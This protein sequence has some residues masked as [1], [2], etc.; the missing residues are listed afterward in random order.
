MNGRLVFFALGLMLFMGFFVS[1]AT[2]SFLGTSD[3][4]SRYVQYQQPDFRHYYSSSQ[5]SD[6]WPIL[7]QGENVS[8][9]NRQDLLISVAPAG[10]QPSVLRSDLLAEQNVPIFCQLDAFRVNPLID[11]KQIRNIRFTGTYPK[12]VVGVG[13]HP[14]LAALQSRNELLGSPFLNNIGYVVVVLR[15][16][17]NESQQPDFINF[18]LQAQVDYYAGNALGV[19]S[20]SFYLTPVNDDAWKTARLRQSFFNGRYFVRLDEVDGERARISL[21]Y[22]DQKVGSSTLALGTR[23]DNLLYLPGSYCQLGLR[24]Y[25]D[26]Y[27]SA[28]PLA[29]LQVGDDRVAVGEGGRFANDRCSVRSLQSDGGDAGTVAMTCG[30]RSFTLSLAPKSFVVNDQVQ[31]RGRESQGVFTIVSFNASAQNYTLR[32][33]TG[34]VETV[35]YLLVYSTG[36]AHLTEAEHSPELESYFNATLEHYRTLARDY[37]LDKRANSQALSSVDSFGQMGLERAITLAESLGKQRTAVELITLYLQTYPNAQNSSLFSDRL[38][39]LYSYDSSSAV[40]VVDLNGQSTTIRL[41]GLAMP[42]RRSHATFSWGQGSRFDV[43]LESNYSLGSA[44]TLVVNSLTDERVQVTAVC[45]NTVAGVGARGESYTLALRSA[46]GGVNDQ[47]TATVCGN[48]L[49]L[50]SIALER[51]A[52]IR[53]VPEARGPTIATNFSVGVGIEKRAIQLS[54]DKAQERIVELNKTIQRWESLSTNLGNVVK[55]L[56]AACFATAGVLTVKNFVTGLEGTALARQKVMRGPSGWTEWCRDHVNAHDAGPSYSS[57]GACYKENSA[58]IDHDVS[59]MTDLINADNQRI[60]A[61]ERGYTK[62]DGLFGSY[63]EGE[64]A[65]NTFIAQE[66]SQYNGQTIRLSDGSVVSVGNLTRQSNGAYALTYQE[67]KDLKLYLDLRAHAGDSPVAQSLANET[68]QRIAVSTTDRITADAQRSSLSSRLGSNLGKFVPSYS[69]RFAQRGEWSNTYLSDQDIRAL[70]LEGKASANT[71]AQVIAGDNGKTYLVLLKSAGGVDE[72]GIDKSY[73]LGDNGKVSGDPI[74]GSVP[75][76]TFSTFRKVSRTSCINKFSANSAEVQFY[77][78]EPYKGMPAIVPFDLEQGWYV[79]TRQTVAGLGGIKAFQSSGRPASFWVCNVGPDGRPDFFVSGFDDDI[80][81]QFN[82]DTGAPLNKFSCLSESE[83]REVV[84]RAIR[85]LED[86]A[87]QRL[88]GATSFVRIEG[89]SMKVGAP[90]VAIPGTQCQDFMSPDDCKLLFNVCD[91][92]IC[93]ASRCNFGGKYPVTDVIQSGIVGSVLLCLPNVNEGV[94]M[95]VCLTGI[96][97]GIDGYV[98]VLK[99]HQQCLQE[100]INSGKYIGICDQI[101]AIYMCEFFWRQAAP[102]ANVLLPKLVESLYGQSS[103]ARGGGEYAT[104]QAAWDNAQSSVNYFTQSYAVNSFK[105]FNI[106]SV[107]DAGGEFCKAFISAK[108]PTQFESLIE[109]DSPP[110]FHAWFSQ[111]PYTD[112]TVPATSQYKVFYHIF[113]GNDQGV[114]YQV[115]LKDPPQTSYYQSTSTIQVDG[116]YVPRGEYRTETRDFT[117]PSGYQQ[118][119]VRV[120]D[121]EECGFKE[122]TTSFALNAIRDSFVKDELKRNDITS[123]TD[124]VSGRTNPSALLNPNLQEAAQEALDPAIYNRGVTRICAT[125][126]PGRATD[127]RRFV[128]VGTCND[129]RV[130]CWLDTQSVDRA[131][132]INNVGVRNATLSELERINQEQLKKDDQFLVGEGEDLQINAL[133]EAILG[134]PTLVASEARPLISRAEDLSTHV[135]LNSQKAHLLFLQGAAYEAVT[136]GLWVGIVKQAVSAQNLSQTT[137]TPQQPSA[138]QPP[139]S[140]SSQSLTFEHPI[141]IEYPDASLFVI[142][143]VSYRYNPSKATWEYTSRVDWSAVADFSGFAYRPSF[144]A[145]SQKLVGKNENEGLSYLAQ[146]TVPANKVIRD[147]PSTDVVSPAGG[148]PVA[149]LGRLDASTAAILM[150]VRNGDQVTQRNSGL[151]IIGSEVKFG[152]VKV[153]D[154]KDDVIIIDEKNRKL[155]IPA[156]LLKMAVPADLVAL[157]EARLSWATFYKITS[158]SISNIAFVRDGTASSFDDATR[159]SM[160]VGENVVLRVAHTCNSVLARFTRDGGLETI[161]RTLPRESLDI[162]LS[163]FTAGD[164]TVD[165][166]C[167]ESE[168]GAQS[169]RFTINVAIR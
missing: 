75:G 4:T 64:K 54:P 44:G 21:Y 92:V 53:L 29:Q 154:F 43:A 143:R 82:I 15:K 166:S 162:L 99:S 40:A 41:L 36:A 164:Y 96:K 95:P 46:T 116:G 165:V 97:A 11:I 27:D 126:N 140:L 132:T 155:P 14:A 38:A 121:K 98:S 68:L 161:E 146:F 81:Q 90:A 133:S 123:E 163:T 52:Q 24:A 9:Q 86:A 108:A 2:T 122:V 158:P 156:P 66:L 33:A 6:Y 127:P 69:S 30:S 83:T 35:S 125:D 144:Q 67:A 39:R 152:S 56:K 70:G 89:Q 160:T 45:Q 124:C 32:S 167:T 112:A 120:N 57:L 147:F 51:Y 141:T 93:P 23:S 105:A 73:A 7:S 61:I 1:A 138:S 10:C 13:F 114:S 103:T 77:E 134:K 119:C 109:P 37:P 151:T 84:N 153:G 49:R 60:A 16:Q 31:I 85:A 107:A 150:I 94:Y 135:V 34:S 157:N 65:K 79:G 18:T 168:Q 78:T 106:R 118:L 148:V 8:C 5:I 19:G 111:I 22:G 3:S 115:Y 17:A 113:A 87:Q 159:F 137:S 72:Y 136:R 20:S 142:D 50:E 26:S 55:T 100:N 80:C 110:Q 74:A 91:P 62:K 130:K 58:R 139:S 129:Q 63:V 102:V 128:E 117:A 28:R 145:I 88:Q 76:L 12:E 169:S 42:A 149:R 104:V 47:R 131:I 48:V 71:P 25:F 59:A 101:S